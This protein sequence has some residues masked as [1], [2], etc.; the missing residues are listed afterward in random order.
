MFVDVL[1]VSIFASQG[2]KSSLFFV[3]NEVGLEPLACERCVVSDFDVNLPM[4]VY[5]QSF[6]DTSTKPV[7]CGRENWKHWNRGI[8]Y[9]LLVFIF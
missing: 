9:F 3:K 8:C 5:F 1:V 2:T 4:F 7:V 6:K